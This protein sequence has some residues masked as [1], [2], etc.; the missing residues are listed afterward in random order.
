MSKLDELQVHFWAIRASIKAL[1][2]SLTHEQLK[3]YTDSINKSKQEF[4]ERYPDIYRS[5]E[6]QI[7]KLLF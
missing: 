5:F 2:E 7:D 3:I 4:L 6:K 1:K